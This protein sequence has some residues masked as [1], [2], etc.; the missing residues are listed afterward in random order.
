MGYMR[1]QDRNQVT[2]LPEALDDFIAQGS[3]VRFLDEFVESFDLSKLGFTYG[4]AAATGRPPYHPAD[5]LKLYLYGSMNR[6]NS[7]RQLAGACK[8]NLEVMWLVRRLA[9]DFRTISDFRKENGKAIRELFRLFIKRIKALGIVR[10]E[11]VGIDGSKF[12]AVNSKDNNYSEKKLNKLI[13]HYDQRIKAYLRRLDEND[14]NEGEN[15]ELKEELQQQLELMKKRQNAK[16]ELLQ[17]LK[18]SGQKQISTVDPDSKR[19]KAGDGTVVGYNVQTTVDA[20]HKLIIDVEVTNSGNDLHEL[21]KRATRAKEILEQDSIKV[22][23][24]SGYYRAE[25]IANCEKKGIETYVSKP[26]SP[27]SKFFSKSDF[28]YS[29][30]EDCYICPAAERL[31]FRGKIREH[32]RWLRRYETNACKQCLLRSS[33][34]QRKNGNRRITRFMDEE[35]L[36]IVEQRVKN[37]PEIRIRRKSIVEHPFGTLKRR[38]NGRFL[39]KGRFKAGTEAVLMALAYDLTRLFNILGGEFSKKISLYASYFVKFQPKVRL[40]AA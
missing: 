12:A 22:A 37:A 9:P 8:T 21:E 40:W 17:Q 28:I 5:L 34:T 20:E 6:L 7:S 31:T 2:L 15:P 39:T 3:Y 10:G 36:E 11:M 32:G 33:C 19:M 23:A 18:Q 38:T 24:D 35:L 13:E 26:K 27:A 4:N 29:K 25:E 16:K 1:G 14:S 30:Q